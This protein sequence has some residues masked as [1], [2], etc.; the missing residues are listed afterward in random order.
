MKKKLHKD[1]LMP[2]AIW[3]AIAILGF[4]TGHYSFGGAVIGGWIVSFIGSLAGGYII[5]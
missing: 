2:Y 1:L 4:V 5:S 3:L